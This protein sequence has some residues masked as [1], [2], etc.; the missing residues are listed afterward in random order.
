MKRVELVGGPHDGRVVSID[1]GEDVYR[2]PEI[3]RPPSLI[4]DDSAAAIRYRLYKAETSLD[5]LLGKF[6]DQGVVHQ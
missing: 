1:G 5:Y 2:I 3:D 6:T 4:E